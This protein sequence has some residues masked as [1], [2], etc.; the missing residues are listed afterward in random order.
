MA[1][2]AGVIRQITEP[3]VR[4]L[5]W[6]VQVALEV[7][8]GD[9]IDARS[10]PIKRNSGA[11]FPALGIGKAFYIGS[12]RGLEAHEDGGGVGTATDYIGECFGRAVEDSGGRIDREAVGVTNASC[13]DYSNEGTH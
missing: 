4:E 12:H 2:A 7:P 3:S 5:V 6:E 9:N 10:G 13:A 1:A 8:E 11:G